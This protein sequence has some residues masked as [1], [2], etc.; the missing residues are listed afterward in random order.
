MHFIDTLNKKSDK[1]KD[2][3]NNEEFIKNGVSRIECTLYS[4]FLNTDIKFYHDLIEKA[5]NYF[6]APNYYHTSFKNQIKSLIENIN[7]NLL[8]LDRNDKKFY[9]S[10]YTHYLN[11]H[12]IIGIMKEFAKADE[13]DL[14]KIRNF[15][16]SAYSF[17]KKHIFYI[18]LMKDENYRLYNTAFYKIDNEIILNQPNFHSTNEKNYDIDLRKYGFEDI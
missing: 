6:N 14:Y 5:F 8:V 18:E 12:K 13:I 7:C 10:Y 9:L 4:N 11:N 1:L 3:F 15:I 2:I 16:V 17:H